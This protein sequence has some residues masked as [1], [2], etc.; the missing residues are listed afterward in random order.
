MEAGQLRHR[1]ALQRP[2]YQQDA[3]TGENILAWVTVG[4]VWARIAPLRAREYI[5]SQANQSEITTE[6]FIR[7]RS[8]LDPTWRAVHMVNGS[9]AR[10]YNIQGAMQDSDSGRDYLKLMCQSS[11]NDGE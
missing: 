11:V 8:D 5:S 7:F 9:P 4:T 2:E 6:I 3:D 10:I 1:V